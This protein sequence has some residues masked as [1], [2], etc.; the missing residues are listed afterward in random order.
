MGSC[1]AN[2]DIR[3]LMPGLMR[4]FLRLEPREDDQDDHRNRYR[5]R[6]PSLGR[7]RWPRCELLCLMNRIGRSI[8]ICINP[9]L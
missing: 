8:V 5:W 1:S 3:N 9:R 4:R 2:A 6:E 7:G